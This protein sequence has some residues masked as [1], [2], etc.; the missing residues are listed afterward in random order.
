MPGSVS[1][2][3][4]SAGK[5]CFAGGVVCVCGNDLARLGFARRPVNCHGRIP[6]GQG[7]GKHRSTYHSGINLFVRAKGPGIPWRD[8]CQRRRSMM[9]D[10]AGGLRYRVA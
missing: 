4:G 10:R 9:A 5:T 7:P 6:E 8:G 3:M 2:G 1:S